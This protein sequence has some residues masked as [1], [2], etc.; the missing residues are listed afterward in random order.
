MASWTSSNLQTPL[1]GVVHPAAPSESSIHIED[2]E[3]GVEDVPALEERLKP[4]L[5]FARR[6]VAIC[7]LLRPYPALLL[8]ALAM[9]ESLVVAQ[10][11]RYTA[12]VQRFI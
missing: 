3:A 4:D 10:G 1:L 11:E 5:Q 6:L 2:P 7:R 9:A 8:A 12:S